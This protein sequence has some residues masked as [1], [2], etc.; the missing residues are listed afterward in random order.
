MGEIHNAGNFGN[1]DR[2]SELSGEIVSA[3]KIDYK[4]GIVE[5]YMAGSWNRVS[6]GMTQGASI[7]KVRKLL[8]NWSVGAASVVIIAAGVLFVS[9]G[10]GADMIS[11]T[12]ESTDSRLITLPDG[13]SVWLFKGS[14]IIYPERFSRK[15]REV[16]MSGEV[17][18]DVARDETR[19]FIVNTPQI[20]VSVL[21]TRFNVRAEPD[22]ATV[23]VVLEEGSVSLS[24]SES[25]GGSVL[26]KPGEMA[27]ID[28]R[29]GEINVTDV[30]VTLYTSWKDDF[31]NFKSRTLEEV[32]FMLGRSYHVNICISGE[33]LKQE[34]FSGRFGKDQSLE[35]IFEAINFMTPI[36]YTYK[37]GCYVISR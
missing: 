27:F 34:T 31:L 1:D 33:K 28:S 11:T 17:F 13:S 23:Q 8:I 29:G 37:D 14:T 15:T 21:G 12:N 25:K 30:D 10:T 9:R 2:E 16:N 19:Q 24:K 22:G 6:T 32:A 7:S 36:K 5:K 35:Q 26:L 3:A 18:F 4:K 20:R